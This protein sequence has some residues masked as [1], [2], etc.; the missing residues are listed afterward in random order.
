VTTTA[1]ISQAST[2]LRR[3]AAYRAPCPPVRDLLGD[4]DVD[5]AY[6]VQV[7]SARQHV[8]QG[9][10]R[11]G[12][13]IGLT[14]T[15]VQRQLG[16]DQPDF[17]VLF[18]DMLVPAGGVVP[19]DRLLQPKVE[20]EVAFWLGA[21]LTGELTVDGVRAAIRG[22][23][24]AIEIVDSRIAGWDI[25]IV[26]TIA[27]N[28]SSGMFVL[29]DRTVALS[30]LELAAVTM[31]LSVNGEPTSQGTGRDCLGDPLL[32]VLWLARTAVERGDPLRAGEIV[33]SGAL[34]PMT[35]VRPGD[36]ASAQI[37]GLGPIGVN[38]EGEAQ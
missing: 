6:Q 3:A 33:L 17:G 37:S 9:H 36:V 24:A 1:A 20:A 35:A 2:R 23:C 4:T 12:R 14:S 32:A 31:T 10:R 30:G 34:G 22:A 16:V 15:A 18:D 25:S 8:R 28:A 11:V 21:D 19:R 26:D 13:K 7:A 5:L 29:S 38:F 27:D